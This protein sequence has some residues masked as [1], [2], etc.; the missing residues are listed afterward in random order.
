MRSAS[1]F[2]T[3]LS[4]DLKNHHDLLIGKYCMQHA[5]RIDE[6]D[7]ISIDP[8]QNRW[9]NRAQNEGLDLHKD[10]KSTRLNS[11]HVAISYAVI[12]LKKT[13]SPSATSDR[14]ST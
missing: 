5:V 11:S 2:P 3:R 7:P 14:K 4:S 8:A 1:S 9:N 12:C 6:G 13:K 10:R